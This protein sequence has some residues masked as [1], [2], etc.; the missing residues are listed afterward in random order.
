MIIAMPKVLIDKLGSDGADAL[1]HILND[2]ETKTRTDLV[3]KAD[4]SEMKAELLKWMVIMWITQISAIGLLL[5][6][7]V[8]P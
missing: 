5:L 4:L 1:I 2:A 6:R 8:R 3:T 7:G